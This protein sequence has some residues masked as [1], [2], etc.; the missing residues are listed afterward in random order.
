MPPST[1]K[2]R[3]ENGTSYLLNSEE[4]EKAK[5]RETEADKLINTKHLDTE[6]DKTDEYTNRLTVT[7]L[8][9]Q[10]QTDGQ[11]RY[12]QSDAQRA[13]GKAAKQTVRLRNNLG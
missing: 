6:Y 13:I 9:Q 2:P 10:S 7:R 8:I 11:I 4:T 1:L 3:S 5:T 12:R